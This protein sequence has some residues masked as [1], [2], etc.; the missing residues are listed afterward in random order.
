MSTATAATE[1]IQ[2]D[3]DEL[4]RRT[5]RRT[6]LVAA[7]HAFIDCR[8]PGS[9]RKLNYAI[10]GSGVAE[11]DQ[12]VNL[13]EPHGF[14]LGGAAMPP[15]VTN[16]L[17][18][19]FT[20]E[21]FIVVAGTYRFRW[22]RRDVDG[23][24]VGSVGDIM[25]VPTWIFRGFS[26]VGG[27]DNF[28]FTILG[29]DHTGGLLWHPDVLRQAQGHGLHLTVDNKLIDE[30]A[31]DVVGDDIELVTPLPDELITSLRHY[32]ADEM[33]G[34]VSTDADREFADDALLCT[35]VPGGR[36]RLALVIGHGMT[37]RR[38]QV[39][40]L[41]EPHGFDIAVLRADTGEGLL[42]HRHPESQV[43]IVRSGTWDVTVNDVGPL[44]VTLG[45]HDTL[46]V[47]PRAWRTVVNRSGES[48][49]E[50]IV[51][52]GGDG[53][54]RLEWAPEVVASARAAGAGI[55]PDGYLAPWSLI[56]HSV[57]S[58]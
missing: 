20:A 11:A 58:S 3:P 19:H 29:R 21:V 49:D 37:E 23:E 47:P 12:F 35:A 5:I 40:R 34:R 25:S 15:G 26:N 46:S 24:Y 50:L 6:D 41:P 52:N 31:G 22:G 39:P 54:T 45:Q 36:A 53:R 17:H 8:T 4:A 33:R 56:R 32:S 14:Q 28:I 13:E 10:I 18:L 7:E 30:V 1:P 38:G 48:G 42:R 2:V 57:A 51:I 44:T 27:D 43:L 9:E 16:S 55:D